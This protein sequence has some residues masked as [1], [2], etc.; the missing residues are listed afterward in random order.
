MFNG[1]NFVALRT[2]ENETAAKGQKPS[3]GVSTILKLLLSLRLNNEPRYPRFGLTKK[4]LDGCQINIAVMLFFS[5]LYPHN[6]EAAVLQ[7]QNK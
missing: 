5:I 4:L 1:S 3:D 2:H 7:I 6:N